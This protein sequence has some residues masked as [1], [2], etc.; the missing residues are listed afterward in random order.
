MEK[1]KWKIG[2]DPSCLEC[3]GEGNDNCLKCSSNYYSFNELCLI[4]CP[5]GYYQDTSS[6]QCQNCPQACL[7]CPSG[8]YLF[9]LFYFIVLIL[10]FLFS[11]FTI[12]K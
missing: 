7:S 11:W 10:L 8:I 1:K 6:F 5:T 4:E 2:C 12:N 3:S 9:Y